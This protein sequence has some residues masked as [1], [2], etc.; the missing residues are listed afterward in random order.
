MTEKVGAK[1]RHRENCI[2]E[3]PFSRRLRLSKGKKER[4]NRTSLGPSEAL[5]LDPVAL[6]ATIPDA[7]NRGDECKRRGV[8]TFHA[9]AYI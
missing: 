2:E 6:A 7:F 8:D 3:K 9:S 5:R 1:L 4:L